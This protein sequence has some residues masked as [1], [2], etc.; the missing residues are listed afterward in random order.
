MNTAYL[1]PVLASVSWG[2]IYTLDQKILKG[3]SPIAL[4]TID[5]FITFL[6]FAPVLLIQRGALKEVAMLDRKGIALIV[7]VTVL[8]IVADLLILYGVKHLDASMASIIE[9]SYPF[10]IVLFAWIFFQA[11]PSLPFFIG[12]A[13]IFLGAA[14]ILKFN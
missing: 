10:F 7:L 9:I 14:I 1:F 6:V 12:G 3:I 8:T 5:A 2:L 11:T 13:F 4:L